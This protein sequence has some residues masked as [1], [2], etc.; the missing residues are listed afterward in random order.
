MRRKLVAGNWKMHGSMA[1]N[2]TLLTQL[3]NGLSHSGSVDVA[4]FPSLVYLTQAQSLLGASSIK[5]GAQTLSEYKFGAYTG[6]VSADMLADFGC[7]YVLVGHSERRE[8]FQEDDQQI[9]KKFKAAQ[10]KYL[11]PVLCVGETLNEREAN[12]T[13]SVIASQL[14]VVLDEVG[15]AAFEQAVI[16]YEPVWAIGTGKTATPEMAQEVHCAI[17]EQLALHDEAIAQKIQ[18]L[19]GGSVKPENASAIFA[20]VDVDGALVG[21]A[22]LNANDF[23]EICNAAN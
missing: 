17:R 21:G 15:I 9:A 5:W 14:Q 6:E 20:Q 18:I 3:V 19:Y 4:V 1:E 23:I 13:A 22:S 16:A 2:Q 8:I 10:V 12:Q 11:T 7:D